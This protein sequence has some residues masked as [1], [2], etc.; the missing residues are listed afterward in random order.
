MGKSAR[1]VQ[2]RFTIGIDDEM[3]VFKRPNSP[4]WYCRYY[5]REEAKYY[6]KSLKTASKIVAHEKAKE[7]Y[8]EITS[9][10]SRD[11]KVFSLTWADAIDNYRE[12]EYE[13]FMGG[14]ISEEWFKKKISYLKN[15]WLRFVGADTPVNQTSDDDGREFYRQRSIHLARK[16]TLRIE[17]TLIRSIYSD[18]L[19]PKGYCLRAIRFPKVILKKQDKSRRVDTFTE[20]EWEIVYT[21]M[22]R[23]VEWEEVGHYRHAQTKYGKAENKIKELNEYQRQIEWCRRNVLREF[24][25]ISANLGTRPVSELLNVKRK[26]VNVTKTLFKNRYGDGQDVWKMTCDVFIDSRKTGHR[27]VN[28]IAGLY[29]QRLFDFYETQGVV[30][31][32]DD[33]VFL[34][35]EGRRKGKQ[36]DKY[37]L[38]RLFRELMDYCKLDR[39]HFTPYHLRHFYITTRLMNGVD[40]VLL[41]ENAGNSPKVIFDTYAHIRTRLATQELNKYRRRGSADELGVEF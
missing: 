1:W 16:N 7:I 40:I 25:L 2:D 31:D 28:G 26:D 10:I 17:L 3:V 21:N 18:Y 33:Y 11:E 38:N 14:V 6:Q 8:K 39:I 22:R 41:S 13:R 15:T 32:E 12:M 27:N 29:F 30:L 4:N 35:L 37:V 19:V 5:V 20:D 23:W 36:L 9:L 34:D 24:I